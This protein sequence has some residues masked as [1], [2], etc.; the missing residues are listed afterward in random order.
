M[1]SE[2]SKISFPVPKIKKNVLI[3]LKKVKNIAYCY[4]EIIN[5]E[6]YVKN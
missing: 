2:I 6:F 5:Y 4:F 3:I 1:A